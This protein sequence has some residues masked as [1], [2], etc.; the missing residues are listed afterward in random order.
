M[1]LGGEPTSV[2]R[3]L[4]LRNIKHFRLTHQLFIEVKEEVGLVLIKFLMKI[5][6][7]HTKSLINY[8]FLSGEVSYN[9]TLRLTT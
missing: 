4:R 3:G 8:V 7:T 6:T 9:M 2:R 5:L 1:F